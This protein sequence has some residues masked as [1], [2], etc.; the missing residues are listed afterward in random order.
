MLLW[1]ENKYKHE[2]YFIVEDWTGGI[3]A[4]PSLPGSRVGS[5]IATTWAILLYNGEQYYKIMAKKIMDCT[6]YL[7][8]EINK[9]PTFYVL[10]DPCVNVVAFNSKK[11]SLSQILNCFSNNGWNLNILQNPKA[12]HIC[13]TPNNMQNIEEFIEILK[14]ISISK[15]NDVK[16]DMISIYG[17]ATKIENTEI[18]KDVISGYLDLTTKN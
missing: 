5:Q 18:I 8:N 3:Y 11:Y 13:L 17:M 6:I 15:K 16:N 4:S 10:G 12:L 9:I 14:K 1:R 7:K 2:Q